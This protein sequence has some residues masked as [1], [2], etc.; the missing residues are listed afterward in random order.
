VKRG[1]GFDCQVHDPASS[2]APF[3]FHP[4]AFP[5]VAP[6]SVPELPEPDAARVAFVAA[7][8][9]GDRPGFAR[10]LFRPPRV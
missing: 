8:T 1:L 5:D 3:A 6:A 9:R 10:G 7:R 4:F 2:P